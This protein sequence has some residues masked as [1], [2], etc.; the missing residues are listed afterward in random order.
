MANA[1]L[2][3][4]QEGDPPAHAIVLSVDEKSQIQVLWDHVFGTTALFCLN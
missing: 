1:M 3:A 4:R 2:E